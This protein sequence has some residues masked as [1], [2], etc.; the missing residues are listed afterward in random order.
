[1]FHKQIELPVNYKGKLNNGGFVPRLTT[2]FP[3]LF[4]SQ[5][6][7][8]AKPVVLICPGGGYAHL[9]DREGEP[10]ALKM[11]TL[12][13]CSAVLSYS[14][15][16]M[17]FP[18]ALCDLAES[19]Y[20]L[21][22]NAEEYG[23]NPDKIIVCGFSAGGHLAASLGCYWNAPLLKNYL[24]YEAKQIKP[25]ALLLCYPVITADER[26]TH[27]ESIDF[28]LGNTRIFTPDD[29]SIEKLIT[30]D[31][32]PTFMWHTEADE[33]VPAENTLM[34]ARALRQ[35]HIPFEYHLFGRGSHALALANDVSAREDGS[36]TEKECAVWPE[37]F[38]AWYNG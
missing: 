13:F 27:K 14:L 12:G 37:L 8:R 11:N 7:A 28:V 29:V 17:E 33:S 5:N 31:F 35:K 6:R 22:Q 19:V 20:F 26:F 32:P 4:V 16:P 23:I 36:A 9:S 15:C 25:D 18:A 21:R 1:M 34:F 3:D 24:P 38:A 30:S 2:Y 10:V